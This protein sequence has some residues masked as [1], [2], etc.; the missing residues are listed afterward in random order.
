MNAAPSSPHRSG[1]ASPIKRRV[2]VYSDLASS[3]LYSPSF[4]VLP[5]VENKTRVCTL[6]STYARSLPPFERADLA[7][8]AR[9]FLLA[10]VL[11]GVFTVLLA[12]LVAHRF[13]PLAPSY[14]IWTVPALSLLAGSVVD[15]RWL[16][17][18]VV[19]HW[20]HIDNRTAQYALRLFVYWPSHHRRR[21]P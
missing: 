19:P 3:S 4:L 2:K 6:L 20:T 15:I 13:N 9:R 16:V 18:T 8:A 14:N 17:W 21:R 10:T 11:I 5:W 7:D 12:A 1:V